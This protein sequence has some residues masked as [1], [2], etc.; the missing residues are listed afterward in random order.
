MNAA[1]FRSATK[2]SPAVQNM[3]TDQVSPGSSR[4]RSKPSRRSAA[5][6]VSSENEESPV[7]A[8]STKK[9]GGRRF[10][11]LESSDSE[12]DESLV[13]PA[14][15]KNK[16]RLEESGLEEEMGSTDEEDENMSRSFVAKGGFM[17]ESS[18]EGGDIS[19]DE[20]F[21]PMDNVGK[22]GSSEESYASAEE[23]HSRPASSSYENF[24]AASATNKR[25]LTPPSSTMTPPKSSPTPPSKS[26]LS[27]SS[28]SL[29]DSWTMSPAGA[30][31]DS[32]VEITPPKSSPNRSIQLTPPSPMPAFKPKPKSS[33]PKK[34]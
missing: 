3:S 15:S 27:K 2:R 24:D 33:V 9:P 23:P 14:V 25:I 34:G 13:K 31:D 19:E 16:S 1:G 5:A 6:V 30:G 11:R 7:V 12:D 26:T 20:D 10:M 18:D 4:R 29:N 32:L 22:D 28:A 17:S 8:R 21:I